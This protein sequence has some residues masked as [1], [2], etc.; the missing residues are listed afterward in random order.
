MKGAPQAQRLAWKRVIPLL[1]RNIESRMMGKIG[2]MIEKMRMWERVRLA[3]GKAPGIRLT[4]SEKVIGDIRKRREVWQLPPDV[5]SQLDR[6]VRAGIGLERFNGRDLKKVSPDL[7]GALE[8]L[9]D[10]NW[11]V[12]G[13]AVET[14]GN[15]RDKVAEPDLTQTLLYDPDEAVRQKAAEAL[16]KIKGKKRRIS[17]EDV[18]KYYGLGPREHEV[19]AG[20][21]KGTIAGESM[22]VK[23]MAEDDADLFLKVAP[24]LFFL[25][26]DI[27]DAFDNRARAIAKCGRPELA[28]GIFAKVQLQDEIVFA[29]IVD[30]LITW[31]DHKEEEV[32]L[33]RNIF[34]AIQKETR[35]RI[36]PM[37]KQYY[38][39]EEYIK[40][41]P[42]PKGL[43][44]WLAKMFKII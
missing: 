44:S 8:D 43:P 27:T 1:I 41:H 6:I 33:L 26:E 20:L 7:W 22:D 39:S 15:L 9:R 18:A 31:A 5:L 17:I 4:Y 36:E 42:V 34:L 13:K 14:L 12:R 21:V 16:E 38:E 3:A 40:D 25:P 24:L 35:F 29:R 37:L 28:A 2:N 19:L 10:Q 32:L 11:S 23:G 30:V